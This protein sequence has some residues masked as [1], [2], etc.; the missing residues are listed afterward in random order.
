MR[1]L[2]GVPVSFLQW[3]ERKPATTKPDGAPG[4]ALDRLKRQMEDLVHDMRKLRL[5]NEDLWER[6]TRA[7]GRMSQ[8]RRAEK[9][10]EE[11]EQ[12]PDVDGKRRSIDELILDGAT[13]EQIR[14]E[15]G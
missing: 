11:V 8:R 9:V 13:E 10:A 5:D 3:F 14:K 15:H 4:E 1:I 6:V 12:Q 2:P 7:I